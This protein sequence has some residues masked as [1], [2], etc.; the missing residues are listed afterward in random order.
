MICSNFFSFPLLFIIPSLLDTRLKVDGWVKK[1]MEELEKVGLAYI[2]QSHSEM[3][4]N[5]CKVIR[6]RCNDIER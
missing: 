5:I 6:E 3:N 4:V 2:W 1:L